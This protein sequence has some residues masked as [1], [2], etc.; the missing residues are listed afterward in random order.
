MVWSLGDCMIKCGNGAILLPVNSV[1]VMES[2]LWKVV[3]LRAVEST[4]G[5]TADWVHLPYDFLMKVSNDII[6]KV[7][8]WIEWSM[9]L[10]LKPPATI[11]WE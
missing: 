1:G 4:D 9:I 6:N 2:A 11:E 10:V 7:K 5:M 8:G 3:A